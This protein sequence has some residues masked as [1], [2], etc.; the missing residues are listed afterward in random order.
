MLIHTKSNVLPTLKSP[1]W[2][3]IALQKK[4][5]KITQSTMT[6]QYFLFSKIDYIAMA[7]E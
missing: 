7:R 6:E 5:H 1:L 3:K 2:I 4:T